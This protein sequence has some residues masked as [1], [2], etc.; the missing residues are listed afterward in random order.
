MVRRAISTT[1]QRQKKSR[2]RLWV[3][4]GVFLVACAVAIGIGTSTGR[5]TDAEINQEVKAAKQ[6]LSQR[7]LSAV[8]TS[9]NRIC[10]SSDLG[11]DILLKCAQLA[12][13][14][15]EHGLADQ[16]L[17]RLD[18]T[19]RFESE[20]QFLRGA[21][22]MKADLAGS[23]EK[24]WRAA[25]AKRS[26]FAVGW[27]SLSQ[28]YM[29]QIRPEDLKWALDGLSRCRRLTIDELVVMTAPFEPYYSADERLPI[30]DAYLKADPDD[31]YS[32]AAVARYLL[33]K[34]QATEALQRLEQHPQSASND[35][36]QAVR[37]DAE[38]QKGVVPSQ[39][40]L[41]EQPDP[42][43]G[44]IWCRG[45][46]A[47]SRGDW[48][49]AAIELRRYASVRPWDTEVLY[50]LGQSL[51]R[52]Q[53][54]PAA[55][56]AFRMVKR[57]EE[58]NNLA[59]RIRKTTHLP[60][61]KLAPLIYDVSIKL[62]ELG[63]YDDALL[64]LQFV[65]EKNPQ[66][67]GLNEAIATIVEL[68]QSKVSVAGKDWSVVGDISLDN[69]AAQQVQA[70][71]RSTDS[72]DSPKGT[73]LFTDCH[74]EVGIEFD[75][76]SGSVGKKWLIETLGGGV[77]VLDFDNDGWPDLY[78]CQ[79]GHLIEGQL[80]TQPDSPTDRLYRNLGNGRFQDVT[81]MAG[82]GDRNYSQGCAVGD[83]DNDG[84]SDLLV[85]NFGSNIL[86]CN[87]GDGTF[88]EI[89]A[90]A[91][92]SGER[93]HTS[94]AFSDLDGDGDL[95]LFIATYVKEAYKVCRRPDNSY[96]SCSPSNYPAELDV[97]YCNQG[98]GTFTDISEKS[99]IRVENGKGLGVVIADLNND[100][101][102]D[103]YVTNDG[104]PNFLF[105]NEGNDAEGYPVFSEIG[106]RA[107]C[108]LS[109]NGLAQ[110]GMGIACDDF[111]EDGSLDLLTTNF[112]NECSTLYLNQGAG[113]FVDAT[114][115]A[116]LVEPTRKKLGFGAQPIDF[117]LS[118]HSGV[119]VANGHIDDFGDR[120]EPWKMRP[121]LFASNGRGQFAEISQSS[122]QFF[123]RE[124]LGR[125]VAKVDFN[126]DRKP[127]LVV[128]HLDRPVAILRN[129]RSGF[130]NSISVDLVGTRSNRD[131]RGCR[132][133]V[134]MG[135]RTRM[136]EHT[137]GDGFLACNE[138]R[139]I[140]GLG[141]DPSDYALRI[142]WP[143]GLTENYPDLPKNC[144]LTIIE[145]CGLRNSAE[146][147]LPLIDI[148]E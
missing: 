115:Q 143:S 17:L 46:I 94:A 58:L 71:P 130:M 134:L 87:N 129:D 96:S 112:F 59:F 118:S 92:L 62:G 13:E 146:L 105:Q 79:G 63:R 144:T 16:F 35:A 90:T 40:A 110:A 48:N 84:D 11:A 137:S 116:G 76:V 14:A 88:D 38:L 57:N 20:S 41:F 50:K 30:V 103:I 23:A 69:R 126:R 139:M 42:Q 8:K 72:A 124:Q 64:W 6:S 111:D 26:S 83:F 25:V 108:A 27:E 37:L 45:M 80:K 148:K 147:K 47:W 123:H 12:V 10:R 55:E 52:L 89:T 75:Y 54:K 68:R 138:G 122:G 81:S 66:A 136:Y 36:V 119:F 4:I 113:L 133:Y 127:D 51:E 53:Q 32:L 15:D 9:L 24:F 141:D 56:A 104:T 91:G 132:I 18:S 1:D 100:L 19:G 43:P 78:F 65:A 93:W 82:L 95:D 120:N 131:G 28:L 101:R 3:G 107:G 145:G 61:L 33:M 67:P 7:D 128:G 114:L 21:M 98:D 44:T 125:A 49:V 106:V 86:Y 97:L 140:L 135:D 142:E 73:A 5:L 117:D 99:G 60:I 34:D 121:Q 102:P 22:K 109:G 29:T 77:A 31:A 2:L 85:T 39:V 74:A 70:G